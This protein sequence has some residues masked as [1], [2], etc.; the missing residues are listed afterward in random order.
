MRISKLT[1][2][3]SLK[4]RNRTCL[5][6]IHRIVFDINVAYN[7]QTNINDAVLLDDT[8]ICKSRSGQKAKDH[9]DCCWVYNRQE[10]RSFSI[11]IILFANRRLINIC[12]VVAEIA[13][14]DEKCV[15]QRFPW[16]FY[17]QL[18]A[19]PATNN[20]K[21]PFRLFK[22]LNE[23]NLWMLSVESKSANRTKTT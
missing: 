21:K 13:V 5:L 4:R 19:P 20:R 22:Y 15:S 9:G 10:E 18:D 7:A 8:F 16:E 14:R 6:Y 3:P 2:L 11:T 17:S 12:C 23:I 1:K